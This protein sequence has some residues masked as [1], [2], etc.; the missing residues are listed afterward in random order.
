MPRRAFSLTPPL[1][2]LLLLFSSGIASLIGT[3]QQWAGVASWERLLMAGMNIVL[4]GAFIEDWPRYRWSGVIIPIGS[5]I[6][7]ISGLPVLGEESLLHLLVM[8]CR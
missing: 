7:S 2:P 5:A 6:Y 1:L 4:V 3:M 8:P